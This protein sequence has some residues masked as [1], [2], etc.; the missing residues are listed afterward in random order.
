MPAGLTIDGVPSSVAPM[1]PT[2]TPPM[3]RIAYGGKMGLRVVRSTTFAAR[4]RKSAPANPSPSA[5]P[6]TGWQP[7]RWRRFSSATPSSNSWLPTDATSSRRVS[8]ASIV[9]SSWNAALISGD[10]PTRSPA[11]TVRTWRR[12][13]RA[14]RRSVPTVVARYSAP[15][16][17]TPLTVPLLPAGGSRFPWKSLNDSSVPR[18][19]GPP[20]PPHSTC[21]ALSGI[22]RGAGSGAPPA[23]GSSAASATANSGSGRYRD[24]VRSVMV[25]LGG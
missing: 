15:P 6:S 13:S 5:H 25:L 17:G 20:E 7:P 18:A 9:G 1:M 24:Q 14:S 10:A 2:F 22:H 8:I 12:A 11:P 19:C 16:A 4:Y 3:V 21:A 23:K